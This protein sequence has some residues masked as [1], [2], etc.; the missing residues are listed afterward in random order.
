MTRREET[1]ELSIDA[2]AA[3]GD[4]VARA[5]D[6][7]VVFVPFTAPGDRVEVVLEPGGKRF[8]RGTVRTVLSP[9]ALRTEPPCAVFGSCGGCAWQHVAYDAQVAAK[10]TILRDALTRIGGLHLPGE[11]PFTPCPSPYA[12]RWR[13]R[14]V[15]SKGQVGYRRRHSNAV[16]ATAHCPI[17]VPVLG[18][19]LAALAA[20]PPAEDGEWEIAA[21]EGG[22]VRV[23]RI[24]AVSGGGRL[25]VAAGGDRI[26]RTPG[27][28]AQSNA[29]L[30]ETLASAVWRAA[31]DGDCVLELFAGAGFFTLGLARR[32][33][34]V[35]AAEGDAT[36]AADLAHN[37]R[38]A[39]LGNVE[40]RAEPVERT[41]AAFRTTPGVVVLDPPRS[42]MPRGLCARLAALGARRIVYLSCDPAT[43]A[44][45][46]SE[47]AR[48][49]YAFE[50][51]E[52]FDLFPQTPH[53]EAMVTL[54]VAS[55][56]AG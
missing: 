37:I 41:L 42:G 12:Y 39:G 15:V 17:L 31:G 27:V 4:G 22:E 10:R 32:F 23:T 43:L 1:A 54:G 18:D 33:G 20:R 19:A 52:G 25:V 14:V 24:G 53:L 50:A 21:G 46:V 38:T 3:G 48:S 26:E 7:R 28:F 45:D 36:A 8:A 11:I 47:L 35:A 51:A 29:L 56:T 34:H 30:L 5:P 55:A 44:R 49:G 40:V 9:S 6:G 13:T 16:C 2:L